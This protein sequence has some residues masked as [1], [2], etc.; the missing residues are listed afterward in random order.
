S[1]DGLQ[2]PLPP[3][4]GPRRPP[5]A[6]GRGLSF[7]M[8]FNALRFLPLIAATLALAA[9]VRVNVYGAPIRPQ[10]AMSDTLRVAS[11][12]VSLYSD[13]AGGLV[14]RLEADRKSTRLNSSHV[15]ISYAVFCL[16][17]KKRLHS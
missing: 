15:K 5:L 4:G 7:R 1:Q 10:A 3:A 11:Y 6:A 14:Q 12:N 8:T 13:E 9:G 2:A 16:I 17:K